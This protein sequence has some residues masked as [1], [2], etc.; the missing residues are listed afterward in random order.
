[1]ST[2][3]EVKEKLTKISEAM[4]KIEDA[5]RSGIKDTD[6]HMLVCSALMAVTRNMYIESLGPNDTIQMF[7]AVAD[8]ILATEEM[9]KEFGDYEKPTIH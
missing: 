2:L 3:K 6:D 4:Q 7:E 5:A 1:M 8:S 9:I